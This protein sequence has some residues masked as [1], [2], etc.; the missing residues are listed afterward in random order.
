[1]KPIT[2]KILKWAGISI[3]SI[4]CLV[5]I[6]AVYIYINMPKPSGDPPVLQSEL[7]KKPVSDYPV[8]GRFI[9]KT[10]V[11]LA[12]MIRNKQATSLEIVQE[13]INFIKNN[14]FKTN[15]F[16]WLFED[17]AIAA[18]RKADEMVAKG[19]PLG[20]LHGVPVA[21]KEQIWVKGKYNTINSSQFQNF[22]A[23]RNAP[24]VDAWI[25]EGAIVIGTTNV[26][27][28]LVDFQTYGEIYPRGNN[29]YDTAYTCGGSTG[30][31]AA[32]VAS[33]FCP[34]SLGGDMGG[35]VRVPAAFCGI[36]GLKTT[37]NSIE[38]YGTFPDTSNN[39][40]YVTMTVNGPQAT[41]VEDIELSWKALVKPWYNQH[42]WLHADTAKRLNEYKV[43][44]FN[45][46]HFGNSKIPATPSLTEKMNELIANIQK[47]GASVTKQEPANFA[48][49]RQLHWLQSVYMMFNK[50]PWIIRQLIKKEFMD[51]E[52]KT[53]IDL[54]EA[55]ERIS[56]LSEEKYVNIRM[57]RDT[58]SKAFERFFENYDF[59][60]MPLTP[61]PAIKHNPNHD[62]IIV[63]N[64][65][66]L[67]WDYFHYPMCANLTGHPALAV[68]LGLNPDGLPVAVQV[69]GPL[70]SE[71][72]LIQFGKMIEN[73]H[74]GYV[75]PTL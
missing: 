27:N 35:S 42:Q 25:N 48:A 75:R 38:I 49:M 50:Q 29:P 30:G 47:S 4:V 31:G 8:Q 18:A 26:P 36:Y 2:K 21:I 37:E 60:I 74:T 24:I 55:L 10:A 6:L 56:D 53:S 23:P 58:L 1:M 63:E 72:R 17:E 41:T 19:E 51:S 12:G 71:E 44:W 45:E 13:H 33:G 16:V 9:F 11:E 34:L 20:L 65:R 46:W 61:G 59:L 39:R 57:R 28:M 68:P 5:I 3:G 15:A 70:Y 7:F 54:S 32:A 62:P 67:Y 66:F 52:V 40:K 73:L 22:I 69:I 64:V 14:N 43:A